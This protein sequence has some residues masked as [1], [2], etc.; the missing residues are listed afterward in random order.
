V[1]ARLTF[2]AISVF[3]LTMNGLLWR[4]EFGSRGGE[5]TVPVALVWRKILTAPDS[6][7]LS[8]YQQGDRMGYCEFATS[9]GQQMA[10]VDADKPPP[11]ALVRDAGYQIHLAGNV[12]FGDFT[13]RLKFDGTVRFSTP[14]QWREMNLRI[15]TRLVALDIHS[16]ATNQSV[17]FRFNN[18]GVVLERNLAFADL[19]NPTIILHTFLGDFADLLMNG[20]DL[21][22]S[23]TA[24]GLQNLEW[25]ARRTRFKIGTEALPVYLLETQAMGYKIKVIVSTLGE[26]LRV[27]LPGDI[28]ARIDQ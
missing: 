8:V 28:I 7:S 17:H 3:W 15:S 13:N 23:T 22:D 19:H 27:E 4:A 16:L 5:T 24:A 12:S 25:T 6:S 14:R 26:I 18:E 1:T 11:E 10:A 21:P 20:Y 9:I 2:I